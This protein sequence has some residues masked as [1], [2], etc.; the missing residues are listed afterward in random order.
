MGQKYQQG[1]V[2]E[3]SKDI[4]VILK[5]RTAETC[6]VYFATN[7]PDNAKLQTSTD[8]ANDDG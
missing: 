5:R 3:N 6:K 7:V 1:T 2:A 4:N 8:D